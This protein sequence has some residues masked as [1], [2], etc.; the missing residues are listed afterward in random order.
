MAAVE[1]YLASVILQLTNMRCPIN[2]TT[3][4]HLANSMIQETTLAKGLNEWKM[5]HNV[6]TRFK[7]HRSHAQQTPEEPLPASASV[8]TAST[9]STPAEDGSDADT[10]SITALTST[11]EPEPAGAVLGHG[12]WNGFMKRHREVIRSKRS[13]KFEAKRAEWCTYNNFRTMYDEIYE[14]MANR[15]IACKVN[16]KL[17]LRKDG[18]TVE[19]WH[20]AFGLAT[21]YMMQRPYKLLFADE[22]G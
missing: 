17:L 12:Y 18:E 10:P 3:G 22:V 16:Q 14:Q 21:E 4:L 5:K 8:V 7:H 1:P 2:A 13:I 19:H 6:K 15:G 20:K 9:T 11:G